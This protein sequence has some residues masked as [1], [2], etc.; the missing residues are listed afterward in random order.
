MSQ[1]DVILNQ[2]RYANRARV[3]DDVDKI[4]LEYRTLAARIADFG[5]LK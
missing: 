5:E 1:I 4:I 3:K 2:V